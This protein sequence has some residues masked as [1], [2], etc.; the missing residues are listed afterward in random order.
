MK[1]QKLEEPYKLF[2]MLLPANLHES[3][4]RE[5]AARG[6]SMAVVVRQLL[7]RELDKQGTKGGA[8]SNE[9]YT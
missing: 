7:E 9:K 1:R 6:V 2:Q 3:L 8:S 5:A 4:R